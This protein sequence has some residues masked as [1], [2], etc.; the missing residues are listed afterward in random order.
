MSRGATGSTAAKARRA[1]VLARA[2]SKPRVR[3][4]SP[5]HGEQ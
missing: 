3:F 5:P 2:G 4:Y 1:P